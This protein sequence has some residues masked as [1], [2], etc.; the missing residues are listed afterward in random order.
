MSPALQDVVSQTL[1]VFSRFSAGGKGILQDVVSQTLTEQKACAR[2][3]NR[4]RYLSIA[5]FFCG[6]VR[7]S[8]SKRR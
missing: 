4:Y 5:T 3:F 6:P 8:V 7:I 2:A 1:T